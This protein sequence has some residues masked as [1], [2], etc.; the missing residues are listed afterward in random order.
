MVAIANHRNEVLDRRPRERR[1]ARRRSQRRRAGARISPGRPTAPGSRTRSRPSTRHVRDQA[2]RG[3][4]ARPARSSRSPSSATTRPSFDPDGRYLYFLSLRTFDP[5]YDSVQF[6]LSFPRAARPY[7]IALQARR[8]PPFEPRPKGLK[9]ETRARRGELQADAAAAAPIR[10]DLD[11]IAQ[12]RRGVPGRREPVRPD[13]RRRRRQGG[14]ERA[15]RSSARTAAAATR[16]RPASSS[17]STSRP[18]APRPLVDKVDDFELAQD[19]TTLVVRDGKRL[20]AIAADQQ[21]RKP[22][23]GEKTPTRRRARAAGSTSSG[24][25]VVGRAARRMAADAARGLAPAAR[26]VL[27]RRTCRASTGR[28]STRSYAPLVDARGHARRAVRPDL[29]DA[30]R[31]R[32][33]ARLRDGRRSPQA[34]GGGARL[35]RL[36]SCASMP[37]TAATRSRASSRGDPWDAGADSPLNAVG[38]EAKVGRADR[39]RQRPAGVARRVPP[40]AL[41]VH[42]AGAKVELTLD[43][44]PGS[45]GDARDV[46]VT[47]LTDEVP[48][49]YREWVER[50]RAWVHAQSNGRVGYF[51]LPDMMAGRLRRVPSLL[52]RRVRPRR[53]DRRRPLQPRRPRLA[54]AAR[55]GARARASATTSRAGSSRCP[56]PTRRSPARWWRSPTSTPAPT[57]TSSRTASS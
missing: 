40:Q 23:P 41:L 4:G 51:H 2:P 52:R 15:D 55:E 53:A 36:R 3:R 12:P 14:L 48:A 45:D 25:R 50:N 8:A 33:V 32:H 30:G 31:A 54:A 11:G 44:R 35:S 13:R 47:T 1:A 27:G 49:R 21:A 39:R 20:R 22:E 19:G 56:I 29:G 9:A 38:V 26:P 43:E 28:R 46:T 34:A 16:K 10:V 37:T 5:V 17:C 18:A 24:M 57:A 6:E 7:L 42:Q